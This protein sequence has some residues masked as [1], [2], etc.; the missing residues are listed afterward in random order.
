MAILK[1]LKGIVEET[2]M[3]Y[4]AIDINDCWTNKCGGVSEIEAKTCVKKIA[5]VEATQ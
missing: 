5:I 3:R 2:Y 1:G 4:P